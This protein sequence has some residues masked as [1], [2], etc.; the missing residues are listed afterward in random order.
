LSLSR[1]LSPR[2]NELQK[3]RETG[4]EL[5][6][7]STT[8][9]E[10]HETLGGSVPPPLPPF[11]HP[12]RIP[13]LASQNPN[14]N[15]DPQAQ[16]I[17]ALQTQLGETQ[18]ALAG[19][20]ERIRNLEGLLAEHETIKREVGALREQMV[21]AKREM[22]DFN[23][24]RRGQ[25]RPA[26]T[27]GSLSVASL[28]ASGV[29]GKRDGDDDD[30]DAR[31]VASVDTVTPSSWNAGD[32]GAGGDSDEREK[33]VTLI[34][35]LEGLRRSTSSS[36]AQPSSSSSG[37]DEDGAAALREQRLQAQNSALGA[38][39]EALSAELDEATRL[40]QSLRTQHA[41]V[42]ESVRTL[43]ERIQGLE[44]AVEGRVASAYAEAEGKWEGWKK[45]FEDGWKRER[46]SWEAER[47]Y[48]RQMLRE[49]EEEARS[50]TDS[51]WEEGS[52][53]DQGSETSGTS[54][55][56][57]ESPPQYPSAGAAAAGG[58]NNKT[59]ARRRQRSRRRRRNSSLP[60][61]PEVPRTLAGRGASDSDS[62]FVPEM[63]AADGGAA[64]AVSAANAAAAAAAA[65][66]AA[67]GARRRWGGWSLASSSS[68]SESR[69][70]GAENR[71]G[72][73]VS[74]ASAAGDDMS[75]SPSGNNSWEDA[76]N[77][78][79]RRCHSLVGNTFL[80]TKLDFVFDLGIR[81]SVYFGRFGRR[82]W[83]GG[84][85]AR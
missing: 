21:E 1:S 48:L 23:R 80:G 16:T 75:S 14:G 53:G 73:D 29:D 85:G 76:A 58:I 43:E 62:T 8:M 7:L 5:N 26:A 45:Q 70:D 66:G 51:D 82:H 67:A 77:Q 65:G 12:T 24:V 55:G 81:T 59:K 22:D 44:A 4:N 56:S 79:R 52:K 3:S 27:N 17:V 20:V 69:A 64:A 2:Q 71:R 49:W 31:S 42:S 61:S 72:G 84:V 15:N 63:D 32:E 11:P 39:L 9:N 13:P 10:I 6:T 83:C 54:A 68:S 25:V 41:L 30:D 34:N 37:S 57:P 35:G 18:A 36:S 38:R 28:Q 78:V 60:R 46:E 40:G 74:K 33:T 50:P 47:E 19:H